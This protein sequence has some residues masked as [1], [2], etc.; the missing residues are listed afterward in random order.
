MTIKKKVKKLLRKSN[1][2][3]S[4]LELPTEMTTG[5]VLL[6][7]IRMLL[8][9]P[10]KIGKTTLASGWPGALFLATE[11]GYDA[12][13]VYK[14]DVTSWQMFK[15]I[16]DVIVAGDHKFKTVVIDT[17]D[18]LFKLCNDAM[19]QELD[20]THVSDE[21]WGKGY[22]IVAN[23]FERVINKLFMSDY[24]L[25]LISHTK[26]QDLTSRTGKLS[27]VTPTLSNQARRIIIPKVSI[28]G[29]MKLKLIKVSNDKYIEK[30]VVS[31]L[32]S[33]IEEA[34]DRDGKL[35]SELTVAKDPHKTYQLFDDYYSGRK[36]VKQ[37]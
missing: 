12:I 11:K 34:G 18:L 2:S 33:E 23:E 29:S 5:K 28:I 32:P 37:Q 31:F 14:K 3:K 13:K 7:K 16:V 36:E 4:D 6:S 25:I 19:C 1:V 10:P 22:D 8:Y 17:A 15:D 35:P 26:I 9:G 21:D 27:K 20:I 30:R 24:G